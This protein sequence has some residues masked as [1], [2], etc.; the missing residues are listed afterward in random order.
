MKHIIKQAK[1]FIRKTGTEPTFEKS[2]KFI[3]KKGYCV[4]LFDK[5]CDEI[6]AYA[7]QDIASRKEAFTYY[8]NVRIVF[9]KKSLDEHTK[10]THLLHEI[11]HILLG[12]LEN[13][14]LQPETKEL[15]AEAFSYY[16][17]HGFSKTLLPT[18]VILTVLSLLLCSSVAL[19][20][21]MTFRMQHA[22]P[23]PQEPV[24]F[25]EDNKNLYFI[26]PTGN[27]YH[28]KNCIYAINGVSVPEEYA[29]ENYTPCSICNPK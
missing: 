29:V 5:N 4:I 28:T 23:V 16:A 2:K 9:I 3:E 20:L 17:F 22:E 10:L 13:E 25:T 1:K 8:D 11:G 18:K 12:H 6:K 19:N 21:I 7:L 15:E 24:Y 26:T 14:V 27:K